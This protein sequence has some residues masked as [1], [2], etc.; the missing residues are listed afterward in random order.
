LGSSIDCDLVN[1]GRKTLA[2]LLPLGFGK[3]RGGFLGAVSLLWRLNLAEKV[4]GFA[5]LVDDSDRE[6][7]PG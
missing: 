3:A 2:K 6:N 7:S 5:A 1:S 4:T